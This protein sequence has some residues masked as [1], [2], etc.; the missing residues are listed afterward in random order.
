[1]PAIVQ[2]KLSRTPKSVESGG[3][4]VHGTAPQFQKAFGKQLQEI[5]KVIDE[6]LF[7]SDL[8]EF[9][10][11]SAKRSEEVSY[12]NG[13][14]KSDSFNK[15]GEGEVD[16]DKINVFKK[17]EEVTKAE[18]TAYD[19]AYKNARNPKQRARVAALFNRG[20]YGSKFD[21]EETKLRKIAKGARL[22]ITTAL[23]KARQQ[24]SNPEMS[25]AKASEALNR[26]MNIINSSV[27]VVG[28]DFAATQAQIL[29]RTAVEAMVDRVQENGSYKDELRFLQNSA[30][31]TDGSKGQG[32]NEK[33]L[34]K[35]KLKN[36]Q[37]EFVKTFFPKKVAPAI[38]NAL[39]VGKADPAAGLSSLA[40]LN[41]SIRDMKNL[42]P[43]QKKLANKALSSAIT[44]LSAG[45]AVKGLSL[46]G[47]LDGNKIADSVIALAKEE[48]R[49]IGVTIRKQDEDIA[50]FQ[51]N[52]KTKDGSILFESDRIKNLLAGGKFPE[53]NEKLIDVNKSTN[54][55]LDEEAR[56]RIFSAEEYK[57][58]VKV[59]K[60]P[61]LNPVN[62]KKAVLQM[63]KRASGDGRNFAAVVRKVARMSGR[64]ELTALA[65]LKDANLAY[66]LQNYNPALS[67][68]KVL[69][70]DPRWSLQ[71]KDD[72]ERKYSDSFH[73]NME[74]YFKSTSG[75]TAHDPELRSSYRALAVGIAANLAQTQG[76]M[77]MDELAEKTQ[78]ILGGL[79]IEKVKIPTEAEKSFLD[80]AKDAVTD[81][82]RKWVN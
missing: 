66:I 46:D 68:D 22:N 72:A 26:N 24:L 41:R 40:N 55:V 31:F 54:K 43:E 82:Y 10:V 57:G 70:S 42:P 60:S 30:H 51:I 29:K 65:D 34:I 3:G 76:F 20:I 4:F 53:A 50:R 58:L 62:Y 69:K 23:D 33:A 79:G 12:Y 44:A 45:T 48:G 7:D 9:A 11:A 49:K 59:F 14:Y 52:K 27:N 19:E 56:T 32:S 71:L 16:G 6:K 74:D 13:L 18:E 80:K 77:P 35:D 21:L 1:M 38:K 61:D 17:I 75:T 37:T 5:S 39:E 15:M 2:A 28:K 73:K 67:L 63:K 78:A 25:P 8:S 36:A 47:S 64:T 81:V